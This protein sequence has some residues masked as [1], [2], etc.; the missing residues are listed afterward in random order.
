MK[1]LFG[2]AMVSVVV[3]FLLPTF[4]G[5]LDNV[6][7]QYRMQRYGGLD[8]RP[9]MA[10]RVREAQAERTNERIKAMAWAI[11]PYAIGAILSTLLLCRMLRKPPMPDWMIRKAARLNCC[12]ERSLNRGR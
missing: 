4:I 9:T 6:S 10:T 7:T 8:S 1:H 12:T 3:Y 5:G 11:A 2:F